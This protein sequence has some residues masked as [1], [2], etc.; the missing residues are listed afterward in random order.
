MHFDYIC[1]SHSN[2]VEELV[3]CL[4]LVEHLSDM[5]EALGLIH[6]I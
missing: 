5:H 3:V 6:T 1:S 4:G 2:P